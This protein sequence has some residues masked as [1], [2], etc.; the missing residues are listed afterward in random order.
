MIWSHPNKALELHTHGVLDKYLNNSNLSFGK[1][2]VIFH[3]LGKC[4]P[5]FQK[6]IQ[7]IPSSGYSNHAYLSVLIFSNFLTQNEALVRQLIDARNLSEFKIKIW[8][9]ITIIAHHHGNIPNL[10]YILNRDELATAGAFIT[11]HS[12]NVSSFI[13]SKLKIIHKHFKIAYNPSLLRQIAGFDEIK[14]GPIWQENALHNFMDTQFAF[15]ALIEA[16][17]RDASD[18]QFYKNKERIKEF[19]INF[20]NKLNQTF[21]RIDRNHKPSDINI[22]RTR[23]RND[24]INT[25]RKYLKEGNR[26]F[27]LPS[28]TGSGKTYT[29]LA[30]A[31]QILEFDNN[32]GITYALPFL[33]I[34]DQVQQIVEDMGIDC[35]PISSKSENPALEYAQNTYEVNPTKENLDQLLR[36]SFSENTF[37]HPFILTTFVQFFET[38]VS[39]KNSTLLKLPNFC[40]RIFLIDEIQALPPR[41]YIFFAAWLD[42]FCKRHNAYVVYST[43]TMPKF[44]LPLKTYSIERKLKNPGS[45][46]NEL[47]SNS[48]IEII[49]AKKIF[50]QDVFNRYKIDWI[51]ENNINFQ[52][53]IDHIL[54]QLISCLIILN[55]IADTKYLYNEIKNSFS[56]VIL[57]NTHFVVQ[58][59]VEKINSIKKLLQEGHQ[60]VVVSTQLIEAGVDL[61]FPVIYRDLC[62]L[63]SIIQSAGRCNRNK[64][65]TF[66]QVYLFHLTNLEGKSSAEMVYRKEAK[67]FI[68][69]CKCEVVNATY[70]KDLFKIQSRFFE[71]IKEELTIGEFAWSADKYGNEKTE[72]FIEC[73]N[74]GDFEKAGRFK[75]IIESQFG[76]SY[77]YFIPTGNTD[78][79][80]SLLVELMEKKL[81]AKEIK[82]K[83]YFK[84]KIEKA[85]KNISSRL[86]TVRLKKDQ[87]PPPF[88]NQE[89]YFGIRVLANLNHYS[90]E[91]GI[92][93]S[94]ENCFL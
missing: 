32:L 63:P 41:L 48:V 23:I 72:N 75:L 12:L 47:H 22:I 1:L 59:R 43:G 78:N 18:N 3:D 29:L 28:P 88:C 17:K 90:K 38:L 10:S 58:D 89:E 73:I 74:K 61:D 35:L 45:L 80:Y 40:N 33:S 93:L 94:L 79:R 13:E 82:E 84:S 62:P 37:D 66:G 44:N 52:E 36:Q 51:K 20:K 9:I 7:N 16:D 57:L 42:A 8:Q 21:D 4:N 64:L 91:Q 19:N 69:F 76:E 71:K 65:V 56:H 68:N 87:T 6:K 77:Q 81:Q 5:N 53:L 14:H 26:I 11:S 50:E 86:L 92:E 54:K 25:V 55:T 39:N 24:A 2:A 27:S 46:F 83:L 31:K 34:T 49:E 15:A 70:E 30:V 60:V 67:D 85:L